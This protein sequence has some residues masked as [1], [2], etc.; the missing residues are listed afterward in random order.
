MTLDEARYVV[1]HQQFFD[2]ATIA[3]A[4]ER[5]MWEGEI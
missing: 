1:S 5:L 3:L 4:V 2:K